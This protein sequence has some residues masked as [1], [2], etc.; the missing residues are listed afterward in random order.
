MTFIYFKDPKG[1]MKTY[2]QPIVES[3]TEVDFGVSF[4]FSILDL[5]NTYFSRCT[6]NVH[7]V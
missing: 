4:I 3:I 1:L 7:S 2:F 5:F 6:G